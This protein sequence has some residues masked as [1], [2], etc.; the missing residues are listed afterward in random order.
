VIQKKQALHAM[1]FKVV[2]RSV[3]SQGRLLDAGEPIRQNLV[4]YEAYGKL[5][6][7]LHT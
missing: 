7:N 3:S 6:T 1:Q 5:L 2:K 4:I